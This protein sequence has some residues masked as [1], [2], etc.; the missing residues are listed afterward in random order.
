MAGV[1][2]L[3]ADAVLSHQV[4]L[5]RLEANVRARVFRLIGQMQKELVAQLNRQDLTAFSRARTEALLKQVNE[6]IADYYLR[7]QGELEVTLQG[8][9]RV[10]ASHTVAIT[11][12]ANLPTDTFF[13][14]LVG[15]LLIQGAPSAVWW[16]RQSGD[17][18]FRF[19]SAVRT[20]L[21]LGETNEQIVRRIVGSVRNGIPGV[22]ET[23]RKNARALV[24]TSIQT[25][26]NASRM[27]TF[28]QNRETIKG[29][30]QLSTL[31]SHTTYTCMAYSGGEWNLDGKPINGT[32][33]PFVNA[34]G[35]VDGVP[36][37]WNC[38]SVLVPITKT[39]RELGIDV[40]EVPT[41]TRA[42]RNGPVRANIT[43]EQWLSRRTKAQQDEQLG[44]GRAQLW[45]E[46]KITLEQLL[47][48]N[49]NP[50]TLAQ[51][52]SRYE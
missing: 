13:G 17:L 1:D 37:H 24:H 44:A 49:G 31:D 16:S 39:F 42:S 48:F 40:D 18:A 22:M 36:R 4:D 41:G 10:Q 38:R 43:F 50:L 8:V 11:S 3:I 14:R 25:V 29:V 32:K 23:S 19:A 5:L 7:A 9:A 47:S 35:S 52:Q 20:G 28:R 30:R 21:G 27:E 34:G 45:R 33:L 51:L 6:T 12:G 46:G 2:P 26:A 15:R